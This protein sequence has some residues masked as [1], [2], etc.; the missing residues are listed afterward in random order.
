MQKIFEK[1]LRKHAKTA[2]KSLKKTD[3]EELN[4]L[5]KRLK[6]AKVCY[7]EQ[8]FE[9]E[10]QT[11]N[12]QP[13]MQIDIAEKLSKRCRV[14]VYFVWLLLTYF[15]WRLLI[16]LDMHTAFLEQSGEVVRQQI[17]VQPLPTF[18]RRFATFA[19]QVERM[20]PRFVCV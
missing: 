20:L 4:A 2:F 17:I 7:L 19:A 13:T 12:L 11:F 1:S 5:L 9:P 10:I 15:Q 18:V 8:L 3:K 14:P 6:P 16:R